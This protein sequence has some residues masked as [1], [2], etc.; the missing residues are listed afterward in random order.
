[1]KSS[2]ATLNSSTSFV[3]QLAIQIGTEDKITKS[4]NVEFDPNAPCP[5]WELFLNEIFDGNTELIDFI[6][7]AVGY[8]LTGSTAEQVMFMCYGKGA[9]GK[10]VF[11]STLKE[12]L[13]A[14]AFKAPSLLFDA[15][16]YRS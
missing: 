1:M 9:N 8:S 16:Q 5:R 4:T 12:V 14:Y 3:V 7:R 6:R 15:D 2:T 13:G 10:S 11:F